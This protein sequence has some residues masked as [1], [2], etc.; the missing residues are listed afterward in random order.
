MDRLHAKD[1]QE[2]FEG[3][4]VDTAYID[5]DT[6]PA[7]RTKIGHQLEEGEIRV[8]SQIATC[9]YG[10]DWDFLG[11]ISWNCPTKSEM[12]FVQGFGRGVRL[13]KKKPGKRLIFIDH[14]DTCARLGLPTDI[15][16]AELC[17]GT[18][19]S[20]EVRKKEREEREERLPWECPVCGRLNDTSVTKCADAGCSH[21][22]RRRSAVEYAAGELVAIRPSKKAEATQS[23]KQLWY[24]SLL[25]VQDQRKY[26]DGWSANQFKRR[27]KEFPDG[28]SRIRTEPTPEVLNY[29]KA[30]QI[31]WAHSRYN[32][33][34]AA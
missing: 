18:K 34:R 3:A 30:S 12:K 19:R 1:L 8:V 24:S 32:S 2:A 6:P 25:A 31:R 11:C 22:R 20:A 9:I 10:V 17:D 23:Q 27:F 16:H 26:K 29:V 28:L 7:E 33:A 14:S 21:D 15:H 4:G 5:K 13:N